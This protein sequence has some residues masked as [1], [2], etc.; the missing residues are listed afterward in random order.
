MKVDKH[1]DYLLQ[2]ILENAV[3]HN[4]DDEKRLWVNASEKDDGYELIV[5]D[6]GTGVSE[7]KKEWIFDPERRFGGVGMHQAIRLVKKYQGELS[8][9][10]RVLGDHTRG[11]MFRLWFPKG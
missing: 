8:V 9:H 1:L 5:A 11:A 7:K 4:P 3:L 2:M 10:D 6:N